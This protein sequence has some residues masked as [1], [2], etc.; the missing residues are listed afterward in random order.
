MSPGIRPFGTTQDGRAVQAVQL[1]HG[2]LSVSVLTLGA[3]LQD[4]RLAGAPWPLT[5]GSDQLAAY[6]GPMQYNG[7]IVGPVANRVAGAKAPCNGA[8]LQLEA[9]EN[10]RTSLHG[11]FSGTHG[12]IWQIAA[13]SADSLTLRLMLPDGLGGYPGNREINAEF[14]LSSDATL[15]LTLTATTDAPS[16]M[17]LA[18]HSYWALDGRATVAGQTLQVAA[19]SYLPVDDDRIPTGVATP[20]S[21]TKFALTSPRL[22]QQTEDYDHNW[23]LASAPREMS[24]ACRLTG[25]SGVRLTMKTTEPGL[26]IYDAGRMDTAP[27]LGLAGQPYGRHAGLALEAQR[28]PNAPHQPD[29]PSVA[30]VPGQDFRQVTSWTFDRV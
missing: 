4:V 21:G 1:H 6:E 19:P 22:L 16:L 7:A 26:Q 11:G 30:L 29:F 24:F 9:N 20:V 25:Q 10:G 23:C 3:I 15:T 8:S 17:N 2:Q 27:H 5:L 18:N 12:Q 28:W 13:A 14:V